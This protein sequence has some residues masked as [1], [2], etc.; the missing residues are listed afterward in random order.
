MSSL[1]SS[2]IVLFFGYQR[3]ENKSASISEFNAVVSNMISDFFHFQNGHQ[4]DRSLI[5][6][7][8]RRFCHTKWHRLMW[9]RF[10]FHANGLIFVRVIEMNHHRTFGT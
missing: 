6:F 7:K 3:F 1:L 4:C 2:F 5:L 8:P 10:R 9:Q